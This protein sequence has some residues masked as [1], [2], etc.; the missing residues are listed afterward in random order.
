MHMIVWL[1]GGKWQASGNRR[2]KKVCLCM[3]CGLCKRNRGADKHPI[4][5]E[6]L[7]THTFQPSGCGGLAACFGPL[8]SHKLAFHFKVWEWP[9]AHHHIYIYPVHVH[10][11]T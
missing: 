1:E 6:G 5:V 11:K 8:A 9:F 7:Y 4:T 2:F 10:S 3:G